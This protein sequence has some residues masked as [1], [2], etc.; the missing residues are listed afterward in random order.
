MR[1]PDWEA[2]LVSLV[3]EA[4]QRRFGWGRFDCCTFA[5]DAVQAVTGRDPMAGLRGYKTW[6]QAVLLARRLGG[7]QEAVRQALGEPLPSPKYAQRG[8]IV[9]VNSKLPAL[10]VVVGASAL[11][12]LPMG[13]QRIPMGDW[14]TGWRVE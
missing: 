8:D 11:V 13:V 2:R 5:A 9:I 14:V 6:R 12:P 7:L 4:P 1:L 3:N 10:G